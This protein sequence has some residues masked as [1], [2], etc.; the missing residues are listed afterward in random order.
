M[1]M[2]RRDFLRRT[3]AGLLAAGTA[4]GLG[5]LVAARICGTPEVSLTLPTLPRAFDGLRVAV[6][7][8]THYSAWV[9]SGFLR[10]V[11]AEVNA[12]RPDLVVMLGDYLTHRWVRR[13]GR[14]PGTGGAPDPQ[15]IAGAVGAVAGLQAPLGVHFVLGNHDYWESGPLMR[16]EL[17]K[18]GYRDL[19]NAG[20]W[21]ERGGARLW[22]GGVDD[23]WEA[24]PNLPLALGEARAGDCCILLTHNPDYAEFGR[25]PRLSLILAGHTHGGQV[26][27]PWIGPPILPTITGKKYASGICRGPVCPVFVTR[28]VG[29]IFPPVRFRCP[30]EVPILT[31]KAV[32]GSEEASA[33]G[34]REEDPNARPLPPK[35]W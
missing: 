6:I 2:T 30:A 18:C 4:G 1:P 22:L 15:R 3:A 21:L 19:N 29:T 33:A 10:E 26:V 28:G 25:D 8:D 24:R 20:R 16:Q 35:H 14:G 32:A 13:Q 34:R 9:P 17:V 7:A 31:L 5:S 23:M 11:M 27:L 12:A